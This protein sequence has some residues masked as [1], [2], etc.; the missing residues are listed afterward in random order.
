MHYTLN[1]TPEELD[2]FPQKGGI[3]TKNGPYEPG[4][5]IHMT[6]G[7]QQVSMQVTEV[8]VL[9]TRNCILWL[10][11]PGVTMLQEGRIKAAGGIPPDEVLPAFSPNE[12]DTDPA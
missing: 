8:E 3:L 9:N 7:K 5:T 1:I 10:K 4:D 6:A 11:Q 12:K 2:K